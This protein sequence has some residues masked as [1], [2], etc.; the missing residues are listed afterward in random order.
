MFLAV[1][2]M[3]SRAKWTELAHNEKAP[4]SWRRIVASLANGSVM[5][6]K[7]ARAV[8]KSRPRCVVTCERALIST[9]SLLLS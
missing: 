1:I 5:A 6:I 4:N 8:A 9:S 3:Y 2:R 7:E